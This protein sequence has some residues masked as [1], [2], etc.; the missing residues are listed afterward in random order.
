MYDNCFGHLQAL[1]QLLTFLVH[2]SI[3]TASVSTHVTFLHCAQMGVKIADHERVVGIS[4]VILQVFENA[5][6]N[7]LMIFVELS[8]RFPVG[9]QIQRAIYVV[10]ASPS[11]C[12]LYPHDSFGIAIRRSFQFSHTMLNAVIY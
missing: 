1:D 8:V 10:A 5:I 2:Y 12:D 3:L 7:S 11:V 9:L 6:K 4:V